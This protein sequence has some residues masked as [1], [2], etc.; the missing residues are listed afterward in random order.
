MSQHDLRQRE[1]I[2][3]AARA[4]A[5]LGYMY[6]FGHV[7]VRTEDGLL[8]TPTRPHFLHQQPADLLRC[9][10]SGSVQAGVASNRPIE[11]FLHLGIYKSRSDVH[12]ICRTHAP[13]AS[14]IQSIASVPPIRHGFGGIT[15]TIAVLDETDLIHKPEMGTRAGESLGSSDALILRGNGVLT[16]GSTLGQAAARMWSLEERCTFDR[17]TPD[18][19]ISF[20]RKELEARKHWYDAESDRIWAW[21]QHV[22]AF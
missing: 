11:V 8:I 9:D 13:A 12:A 14:A 16:V 5:R 20:S 19:N 4:F 18:K 22:G 7:S 17:L 15:E 10:S 3:I 2:V 1:E 6:G 21:L